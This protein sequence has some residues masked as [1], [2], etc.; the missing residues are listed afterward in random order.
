MLNIT[1]GQEFQEVFR[2]IWDSA[3]RQEKSKHH[4]QQ[5]VVKNFQSDSK[6]SFWKKN[7]DSWA[8][9]ELI[10]VLTLVWPLWTKN[11]NQHKRQSVVLSQ[12]KS[13][14]S[15]NTLVK[16][17]FTCWNLF[18]LLAKQKKCL[19]MTL[20]VSTR[21]SDSLSMVL[22]SAGSW[23]KLNRWPEEHPRHCQPRAWLRASDYKNLNYK[24]LMS[25]CVPFVPQ[26]VP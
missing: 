7:T 9:V 21:T 24:T 13:S 6:V 2:L 8:L 15:S 17:F 20:L 22:A 14:F 16:I 23:R 18:K 25:Y 26:V 12:V 5:N 10:S 19:K 4:Q 1:K 3:T 11:I